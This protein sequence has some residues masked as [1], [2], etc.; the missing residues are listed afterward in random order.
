MAQQK[1]PKTKARATR[2]RPSE[3]P[4]RSKKMEEMTQAD[5]EYHQRM[6]E[7]FQKIEEAEERIEKHAKVL[8]KLSKE[9]VPDYSQAFKRL[10]GELGVEL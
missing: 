7:T 6:E 2:K 9:Q 8:S 10:A 1:R 4:I 3:I 5:E